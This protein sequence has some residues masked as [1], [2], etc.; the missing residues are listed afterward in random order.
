MFGLQL[1]DLGLDLSDHLD[2]HH[3]AIPPLHLLLVL[4]DLLL[5]VLHSL[6]LT[7][8]LLVC[9]HQLLLVLGSLSR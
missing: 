4:T 3:V 8:C 7:H 1:H 9:L 6:A 5:D 2:C